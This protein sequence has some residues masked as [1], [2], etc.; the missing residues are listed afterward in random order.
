LDT[1]TLHE[2]FDANA[3]HGSLVD[4]IQFNNVM[5]YI[6]TGKTEATLAQGGNRKGDKGFFIEPTIFTNV[7][8]TAK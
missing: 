7:P 8:E 4:E 6:E 1:D 5:K 3:A 2:K